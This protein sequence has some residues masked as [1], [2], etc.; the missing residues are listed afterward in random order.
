MELFKD[1]K[2]LPMYSQYISSLILHTANNR[3]LYN[4]NKEFHKYRTRYNHNLYL[5]IV[6]SYK[7]KK[8]AHFSEREVF[9]ILPE[10]V[11]NSSNDRKCFMN[12]LK[13]FLYQHS[14]YSIE[15]YFNYKNTKAMFLYSKYVNTNMFLILYCYTR[16]HQFSCISL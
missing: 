14:F 5:P 6:H 7:F 1:T 10:Y 4:T 11:K 9:N 3:H 13:S 8:G 12:N 2:I 16:L 15:E